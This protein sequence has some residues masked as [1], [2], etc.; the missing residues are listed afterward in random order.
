MYAQFEKQIQLDA[1][2]G[3]F[4]QSHAVV[5]SSFLLESKF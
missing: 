2:N 3:A 1:A 4:H 5:F